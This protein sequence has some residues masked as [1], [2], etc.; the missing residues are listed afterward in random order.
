MVSLL[1]TQ[2]TF[3]ICVALFVRLFTYQRGSA[4]FRRGM[5]CIAVLVMGCAG[6]A[7]I[8]ILQG[9]LHVPAAAWPVVALLAV[10]AWAVF[11]SGGNLACVLRPD[12]MQLTPWRGV[13]RRRS[14]R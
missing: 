3:W 1:L 9:D 11:C 8:G 2:A 10:F 12:G 7:C 4:R 14:G 6:A 13:E 5:S